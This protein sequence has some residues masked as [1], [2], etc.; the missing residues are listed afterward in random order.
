MPTG[1]RT[2]ELNQFL[3]PLIL[4]QIRLDYGTD[5][6]GLR[7]FHLREHKW[8]EAVFAPVWIVG[9]LVRLDGDSFI[10]A[11]GS[12]VIGTA[13]RR[14]VPGFMF[15]DGRV[16]QLGVDAFLRKAEVQAEFSETGNEFS[17]LE[18]SSLNPEGFRS[19]Q[20]IDCGFC[21]HVILFSG[22]FADE[23]E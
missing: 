3:R 20:C 11:S 14:V 10:D 12:T 19:K 18:H 15:P 2:A 9:D 4:V 23:S 1:F 13:E 5:D 7:R 8:S 6:T 21:V 17:A 22:G 16:V